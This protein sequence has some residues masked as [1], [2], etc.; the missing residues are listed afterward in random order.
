MPIQCDIVTQD[1][2]VYSGPV[3]Y[4]SLPGVEGRMGIL[5]NHSPMLTALDFGEVVVKVGGKEEFYAIGAGFAEIQPEHV[6]VLAD[7]AE[8]AE[9]ID[10]ERAAAARERA[11]KL[12]K[13][14]VPEDPARFAVIEAQLRRAQLRVDVSRRRSS[15]R[16]GAM[17]GFGEEE[18]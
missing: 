13:E 8:H 12:M 3:D 6:I 16:R 18:R 14:G 4:V 5:P 10:L 7:S 11:E 15:R 17:E 1:R 2:E 9:E